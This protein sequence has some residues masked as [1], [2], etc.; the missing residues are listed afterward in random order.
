MRERTK[1]TSKIDYK[2][3]KKAAL[4]TPSLLLEPEFKVE[5]RESL[6]LMA[7]E[8]TEKLLR[9]GSISPDGELLSNS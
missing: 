2:V 5:R 4:M 8:H 6:G 7:K 9:D 1:T 3:S